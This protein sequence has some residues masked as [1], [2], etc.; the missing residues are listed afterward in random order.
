ME[1]IFVWIL[2]AL[3]ITV[4][5]ITFY[6]SQPLGYLAITTSQTVYTATGPNAAQQAK[7][8]QTGAVLLLLND[9][10]CPVLIIVFLLWAIISSAH[11]DITSEA[12]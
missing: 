7:M 10:W 12:Y 3:M 5:S 1:I 8:T 2:T 4:C 6:V 11:R 9:I